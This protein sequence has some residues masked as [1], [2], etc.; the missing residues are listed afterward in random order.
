M[1]YEDRYWPA[2]DPQV[3]R[4]QHVCRYIDGHLDSRLTLA[5]LGREVS[6]SPDHL[7]RVFKRLLGITPQQ[8]VAAQRL[9]RFKAQ[10]RD[11]DAVTGALYEA[12][13]GSSSRLYEQAPGRL[14]MTPA[15][16]RRGGAGL[17]IAY[18]IVDSPLGR[19]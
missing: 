6:L 8:Y 18:T 7:Q 19:L 2:G 11:G 5:A 17:Q 3:E 1:M 15:A 13:Y 10:V 9:A 12:G 16:Y 14:G 4:V